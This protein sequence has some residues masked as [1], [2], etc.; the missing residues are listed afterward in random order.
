MKAS[1]WKWALAAAA[2]ATGVAGAANA[3][4]REQTEEPAYTVVVSDGP[5]EV[6]EYEPM[7]VAEVSHTG[8]QRMAMG[9]GFR[10]L[11]AYIFAQDRPGAEE[12]AIAMTAP[13][14]LDQ[15]EPIA[16]TAP[17]MRDSP[18]EGTWRTRFVMPSKYTLETLPKPPADI[19]LTEVPAR[20]LA[21]VQF[22]GWGRAEDLERAEEILR[23]WMEEEGHVPAGAAEFAFYDAPG[24]PARFRRNEVLIPLEA[25]K[26]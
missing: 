21:A 24:V 15:S 19:T 17:V 16:M 20:R 22:S 25:A 6:R 26:P 13:V 1:K 14:M 8:S 4:Y 23:K 9:A 3:Q 11:A 10:R 2:L 12:E 7:I 18:S 5:V